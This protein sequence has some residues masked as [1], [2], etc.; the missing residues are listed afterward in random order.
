MVNDDGTTTDPGW[1]KT[2]ISAIPGRVW[3]TWY[4]SVTCLEYTDEI[5]G[6]VSK[7]WRNILT[8]F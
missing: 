6:A 1:K 8:E 5:Y 4:D 3:E 2:S 7:R